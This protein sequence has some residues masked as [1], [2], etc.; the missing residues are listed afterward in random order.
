VPP[1][2]KPTG[3]VFNGGAGFELTPGR[4]A[5]FI[6]A[7]EDGTISG[8]NPSA[9]PTNA[10][11]KVDNS[12]SDAIYKGLAIGN[13]GSGDFLYAANFKGGRIDV[14]D[15]GFGPLPWP[16]LSPILTF[17]RLCSLQHPKFRWAALCHLC[18]TERRWR[19]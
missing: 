5:R 1:P 11:L 12:G 18:P 16:G 19:C 14:F 6:F 17:P 2:A 3:L 15:T 8:W 10:I 9:S 4:P 13:N 7:T